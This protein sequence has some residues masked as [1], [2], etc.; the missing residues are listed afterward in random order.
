MERMWG[1]VKSQ[2]D[3]PCPAP[4]QRAHGNPANCCEKLCALGARKGNGV[5]KCDGPFVRRIRGATSA[6]RCPRAESDALAFVFEHGC[7]L[8]Q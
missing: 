2:V 8:N 5:S 6:Q 3:V 1:E 4:R 7:P